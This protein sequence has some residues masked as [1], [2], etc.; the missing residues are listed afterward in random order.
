MESA[1]AAADTTRSVRVGHGDTL[2]AIA[3]RHLGPSATASAIAREW[4]RW[5]AANRAV[6]G[7]DPDLIVA[8]QV[9]TPPSASQ[10]ATP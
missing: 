8:G 3:A 6:I 10:G 7:A 4:P 5:Y 9:L 1:P 2:W